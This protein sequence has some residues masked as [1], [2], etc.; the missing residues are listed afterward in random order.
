MLALLTEQLR[1]REKAYLALISVPAL[2]ARFPEPKPAPASEP[3]K[4]NVVITPDMSRG[5]T[6]TPP[7]GRN[8]FEVERD[9]E[10][11]DKVQ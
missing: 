2:R 10:T 6:Y 8:A 1:E 5:M 9:F 11:E 3:A 7:V 4:T